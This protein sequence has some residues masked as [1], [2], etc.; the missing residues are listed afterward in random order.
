MLVRVTLLTVCLPVTHQSRDPKPQHKRRR[1]IDNPQ[2]CLHRLSLHYV[3]SRNASTI[4]ATYNPNPT[5]KITN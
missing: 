3:S 2:T 4:N 5:R 1:K